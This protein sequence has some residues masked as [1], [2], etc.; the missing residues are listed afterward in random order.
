[1]KCKAKDCN[2]PAAENSGGKC[3]RCYHATN[4]YRRDK[5]KREAN[6][7]A[8]GNRFLRLMAKAKR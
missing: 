3:R 6:D 2:K 8:M 1:M 5:A 7:V 4:E